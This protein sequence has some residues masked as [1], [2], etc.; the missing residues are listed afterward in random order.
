MGDQKGRANEHC[1]KQDPV[2]TKAVVVS[3]LVPMILTDAPSRL[4][5]MDQ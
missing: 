5:S 1:K 2:V 3:Y 4:T